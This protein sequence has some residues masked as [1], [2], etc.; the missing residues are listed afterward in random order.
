MIKIQEVV[1]KVKCPQFIEKALEILKKNVWYL[2]LLLISSIY[3]FINRNDIYQLT[4]LNTHNLIFILWL[5]LLIL[6]LF[7][8]IEIGSVKLKKELEKTR[9][10]VKES[11]QELK[12]QILDIKIANSNTFVV[13]NQ[14][15]P[16]KDELSQLQKDIEYNNSNLSSE[17][18]DFNIP[19]EN[20]YLFQVRLSLE[21]RLSA[22]CTFF[23]YEERKTTYAMVPF[24]VKHEVFDR[25]T[26]ELIREII[27]IA[28]RGVHGEII[29]KDYVNFVMKTYPA[30][31][32]SLDDAY[33]YYSNNRYYFECPKCG[34]SGP[35]KYMKECPKCG[36]VL[37]KD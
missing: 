20:L 19:K 36:F 21:K 28:N 18:L 30:I 16:S 15:L 5:I 11:I 9:T 37:D 1:T 27:N 26:A 32:Q 10:E 33:T 7:S 34:Y 25:K 17:N 24:L 29:D 6:P 31:K 35:S 14:P 23:Q 8:E 22:L 2:F 4:K 13:N 3:I 12:L